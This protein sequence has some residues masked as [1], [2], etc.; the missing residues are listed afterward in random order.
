MPRFHAWMEAQAALERTDGAV[1]LDAEAAV[2]LHATLVIL[3]GHTE[4]ELAF[5]FDNTLKDTSVFVFLVAL[6]DGTERF[7]HFPCGL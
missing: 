5:W 2:H 4:H 7:E 1:E 3:P 6:N